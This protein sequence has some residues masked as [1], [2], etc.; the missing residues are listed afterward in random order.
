MQILV[1]RDA[2]SVAGHHLDRAGQRVASEQQVATA[3]ELVRLNRFTV[4]QSHFRSRGDVE[5]GLDDAVV[6]QRNAQPGVGAFDLSETALS[7]FEIRVFKIRVFEIQGARGIPKNLEDD[8]DCH[9][10]TR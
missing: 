7:V 10:E 6:A 1:E 4:G 9:W 2:L 8:N 5:T 3:G